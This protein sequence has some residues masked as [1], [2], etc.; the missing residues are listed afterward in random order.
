MPSVRLDRFISRPELIPA[1]ASEAGVLLAGR[2][3]S[4][5]SHALIKLALARPD[6]PAVVVARHFRPDDLGRLVAALGRVPGPYHLLWDD[7]H[8]KPG[9][10]ADAV[11]RLGERGDAL[12]VLAA[13]RVQYESDVQERVTPGFCRQAGIGADPVRLQPFDAGQAAEISGAVAGALG[14]AL[15]PA[16]QAAYARHVQQ[17]DGGPLFALATGLLLREKAEAG[18]QVR[19]VDVAGLP[20]EL[21]DT[22]R[23]LYGR[24]AGRPQ[25]LAMQNLLGVLAFLHRIDC[26]LHTRLSELLYT[27]VLGHKR[28]EFAGSVR[29]LA[30][31]GWLRQ[32]EEHLAAHDVTLEAVPEEEG[33]TRRF[34][35]FAR[36]EVEG[37]EVAT[38]LLRGSLS[39]FYAE[40]VPRAR[41][42]AERRSLVEKAAEL[43]QMAVSDFRSVGSTRY[44]AGSLNSAAICYSELAGL[45]ESRDRRM[46]RLQ[47]AVEASEEAVRIRRELGLQADLAT[48]L[49]NASVFYSD[50][51]RLEESRAGRMERLQRAVLAIVEAV[52]LCRGLGLQADLAGSLNNAASRYSELAS[53]EE[54]RAGRLRRLQRAVEASE[55]AVRIRRELGLQADLASSLN[56]ASVFYSELA[57]LEESRDGRLRRLQRAIE[58]SEEAVR[59]RR[60]LGPQADLALSL[61]NASGLYS[62]LAALEAFRDGRLGRLQRAV[63][64]IEEAIRIRRDL[65]LGA[66][67]A[68]SLSN[69]AMFYSELGRLDESRAGRLARLQHAV[70]AVEEAVV[71]YR[72]LGLQAELATSLSN[73]A[74]F[75]S[76]L[77]RLEEPRAGRRAHLRRA[78]E[79]VEEAV[80]IRRDLGLQAGLAISL[81]NAADLYC[82][83]AGL[84]AERA[85]WLARLGRARRLGRAVEAV[86]E[87]V[88][89]NRELGLQAELAMS[90]GTSALVYRAVAASKKRRQEKIIWL[91]KAL[92][93]SE[94]SVELLRGAGV[95]Q[96]LVQSLKDCIM[97]RLELT[98]QSRRLD[99]GPLLALCREGEAL[100]GQMEDEEGLAFIRPIRQYLERQG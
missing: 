95:V 17:G 92:E 87:A 47:R 53:L 66:E 83:L 39:S 54:S 68:M 93:S 71:L 28:G 3:G 38:G 81:N 86:E 96:P 4:G 25:G 13:Y 37:E 76:E 97:T 58:A 73:A 77:A 85:G 78:V 59:I 82:E 30:C 44:L 50:L 88:S 94:E 45:E 52:V 91:G 69:A 5:K 2:P 42:A 11:E 15:D 8:D 36:Q 31:E 12:R 63:E 70:E 100:C 27:E 43:G 10:F 75:Y 62:D 61:N 98:E 65:G 57:G 14:L 19:A 6:W 46:E 99:S 40:K 89:L 67:L 56:N 23:H 18:D 72:E 84:E 64:A 34:L 49:N 60:D 55:E 26:P 35:K 9:L 90:L 33:E 32:G 51:A 29:A 1:L 41:T 21:L 74:K 7:I 24:L 80:R 79:A 48:S 16:A 20:A 22:W